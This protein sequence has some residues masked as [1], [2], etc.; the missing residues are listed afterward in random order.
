MTTK[1]DKTAADRLLTAAVREAVR[2]M[3][4]G[5]HGARTVLLRAGYTAELLI[6]EAS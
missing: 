5:E 1:A 6:G 4:A 2:R 3:R